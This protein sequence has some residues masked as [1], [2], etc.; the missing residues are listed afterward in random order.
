MYHWEI[1]YT[2]YTRTLGTYVCLCTLI[3]KHNLLQM[4]PVNKSR[5]ELLIE[6]HSFH[7][8][9]HDVLTNPKIMFSMYGYYIT[10]TQQKAAKQY[11]FFLIWLQDTRLKVCQQF[12]QTLRKNFSDIILSALNMQKYR[13]CSDW[14]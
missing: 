13:P 2:V 12:N 14:R 7:S 4:L 3:R 11:A 9:E 1:Y 6:I 5:F 10:I 8:V